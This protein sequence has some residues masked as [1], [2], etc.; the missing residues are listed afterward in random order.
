MLPFEYGA[1]FMSIQDAL[2]LCAGKK[3]GV[4]TA[5]VM[6]KVNAC[7][8]VTEQLA[9]GSVPVYGI[10]TGFGPL[11][12]TAIL[13][14]DTVTL[15][16]NILKSHS[17]GVGAPVGLSIARLMLILK[18]HA[19]AKGYSGVQAATLERILWHVNHNI[20]PYVPCQG[21]V[22]ASGDLA[23]LAHLFLPLIGLGKV[24]YRGRW[25]PAAE[26]MQ[27]ENIIPIALGAKEGLALINGTQFIAA[28]AVEVVNRLQ[29][30]LSQADLIAALMLEGL[31]GS[32]MPFRPEVHALRGYTGC[33]H[34]AMR[35]A[36]LLQHSQL[37]LSHQHCNRV[38]DPYSLRCIPQVHGASRQA[39]LHLKEATTIEINAVTDNPLV[40]EDGE[41][42]SAGNFH[43][44][45]L[46]LPLDYACLAA[47]EIGNI[48]DRRIYLSLTG[49]ASNVPRLLMQDTGLN[50]AFMMPQYTSAAL[51]SE[52]KSLCYPASAD[53]IPTSLG[54]EDHVSMG[55]ISGRKAL[56]VVDNVEKILGIELMNAAQAFDFH[57]PL[58]SGE[59]IN[60]MHAYIRQHI[61]HADTDRVFADDIEQA[62]QLVKSRELIAISLQFKSVCTPFDH[63][64]ESLKAN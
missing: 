45:P 53:S 30:V 26:M 41:S 52:N 13:P 12:T 11:C 5:P 54:Q 6:E 22:G 16:Y 20:V 35:M 3:A 34:V 21:S 40:F 63:L 29:G 39:W 9:A 33:R 31:L 10:N 19:L 24:W 4:L 48:S 27:A 18:V 55:S 7:R 37:L 62:H 50:S 46:A 49:I 56:Q 59:A 47:S 2:D 60:A 1:S 42:I 32:A 51:A 8:A 23:P 64:Y 28:H 43:G 25:T 14:A 44:Q 61:A 15:Q 57:R 58:Q 38:Q 17:V 36:G